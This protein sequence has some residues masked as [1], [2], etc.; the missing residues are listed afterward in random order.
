MISL[1][2]EL[3]VPN[4]LLLRSRH[5]P[6]IQHPF[7]VA[8]TLP[9]YSA[10][11]SSFCK[12]RWPQHFPHIHNPCRAFAGHDDQAPHQEEP[13]GQAQHRQEP[14]IPLFLTIKDTIKI[15]YLLNAPIALRR[16]DHR[17]LVALNDLLMKDLRRG[18]GTVGG[19]T[20][21][22]RGLAGSFSAGGWLAWSVAHHSTI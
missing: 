20:A 18:G 16:P 5:F 6:C 13:D 17:L 22:D 2:Y 10:S 12:T 3:T 9:S 11:M 15:V 14:G 8:S 19:S 4:N 1:W 7:L 21:G